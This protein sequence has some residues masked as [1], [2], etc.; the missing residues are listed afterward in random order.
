MHT[1][2]QACEDGW[3]FELL[4]T[5][6]GD[7]TRFFESAGGDGTWTFPDVT[8]EP[9]TAYEA[10]FRHPDIGD[11]LVGFT[12]GTAA[13]PPAGEPTAEIRRVVAHERRD[14]EYTITATVDAELSDDSGN[15]SARFEARDHPRVEASGPDGQVTAEVVWVEVDAGE[16][17]VKVIELNAAREPGAAVEV[18][19]PID[20]IVPYD[21]RGCGCSASAAGHTPGWAGLLAALWWARR[22]VTARR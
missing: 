14:G 6:E 16:V 22:R 2:G 19:G 10:T 15:S 1:V 8:L 12:T 9:E 13:A 17:C 18:C 21:G 5:A 20:E 11:V 7:D 3:N 4:L